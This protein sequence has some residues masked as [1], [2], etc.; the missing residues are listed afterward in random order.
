LH[1]FGATS[2]LDLTYGYD[3]RGNTESIVDAIETTYSRT[4]ITYDGVDR[5]ITASGIWGSGTYGYDHVGN[6]RSVTEG[7]SSTTVDY[8]NNRVDQVTQGGSVRQYQYDTYGNVSDNGSF[9]FT[10][11]DAQNLVLA[12]PY[13]SSG[14]LYSFDYDGENRRVVRYIGNQEKKFVYTSGGL[15]LGEY[16]NDITRAGEYFYLGANRIA[17]STVQNRVEASAGPDMEVDEGSLVTPDGTASSTPS[18]ASSTHFRRQ[19]SG[20]QVAIT[21]ASSSVATFTAPAGTYNSDLRFEL[22]VTDYLGNQDTDQVVVRIRPIDVDSDSVSDIWET[23]H[24]GSLSFSGSDDPDG[25]GLSNLV[26]YQNST[27]PNV[28]TYPNEPR[29]FRVAQGDGENRITWGA[30]ENALAFDIYWSLDSNVTS[31]SGNLISDVTSPYVH[32][33]VTNGQDYYYLLVARN[34]CCETLSTVAHAATGTNSWASA[35]TIPS[36]ISVESTDTDAYKSG[37]FKYLWKGDLFPQNEGGR[38]QQTALGLHSFNFYSGWEERSILSDFGTN[39]SEPEIA[40]GMNGSAVAIWME[41]PNT[42]VART[43]ERATGWSTESSWSFGTAVED[44]RVVIDDAGNSIIVFNYVDPVDMANNLYAIHYTP[45]GGWETPVSIEENGGGVLNF[46]ISKE[47]GIALLQFVGGGGNAGLNAKIYHP[48]TGWGAATWLQ[49]DGNQQVAFTRPSA[50]YH[51]VAVE[52]TGRMV[53]AWTS[54]IDTVVTRMYDPVVGWLAIESIDY[55]DP[56]QSIPT[57]SIRAT[58]DNS[59]IPIVAWSAFDEPLL[60]SFCSVGIEF[61]GA[62]FVTHRDTSAGWIPAKLIPMYVPEHEQCGVSGWQFGIAKG[63][64][65]GAYIVMRAYSGDGVFDTSAESALVAY[66]YSVESGIRYPTELIPWDQVSAGFWDR[67]IH[68]GESKPV[69]REEAGGSVM[70]FTS[71]SSHEF[72]AFPNAPLV[73]AGEN[74]IFT[75]GDTVPLDGSAEVPGSTATLQYRWRQIPRTAVTIPFNAFG[76]NP[77]G[78]SGAGQ[79]SYRQG[80]PVTLGD[81]SSAI[82]NFVAPSVT[83]RTRFWFELTATDANGISAVDTVAIDVLPP[84]IDPVANAGAD[85]TVDEG[86]TVTLDGSGSSDQD[87][88]LQQY[89]WTQLN[90]PTVTLQEIPGGPGMPSTSVSFVAPDVNQDTVLTFRLEVTDDR[91]GISSDEVA[92]TVRDPSVSSDTMPPVVTPPANITTEATAVLTPVTLGTATATDDVDGALTPTADQSGPFAV[93]THTITWCATD[94]A[95]NIGSATQ[96]VTIQDTTVPLLTVPADVTV[97]A[98]APATVN[99]GNATAA[100]I[101]SVTIT[102]DAPATYPNGSTTV[103]W[104]A[105]DANGNSATGT[106]SV[107]VNTPPPGNTINGTSG[108]DFLEGTA[109]SDT[110]N[111]EGGNDE[112]L[113]RE[114]DDTLNGGSGNDWLDGG[115]GADVMTGGTGNDTFVVDDTGDQVNE[116][117]GEGNDEVRSSVSYVL[118]AAVE[119][120]SLQGTADVDGT[121]NDLGNTMLGNGGANTL[122]GLDGGDSLSGDAGNDTRDGGAGN[123]WLDGGSGADIMTGGTGDDTFIV[124]DAGDQVNEQAGEGSDEVRSHVSYV[125][126]AAVENLNLQ[127]TAAIDGTGNDAANTLSALEGNDSLDSYSGN[128]TLEGGPGNDWLGGGADNDS[129]LFGAGH[130]EDTLMEASEAGSDDQIQYQGAIT[131]YDLWFH[132]YADDLVIYRLGSGDQITVRNWYTDPNQWI[133]R[134]TA[135]GSELT[136]SNVQSLVDAMTPYG[137]PVNGVV[138]LTT[139]QQAID[140]AIDAAWQ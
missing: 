71:Y 25:D 123:D 16:R 45:G 61:A 81:S 7:S 50:A 4:N 79:W 138:N 77:I 26:E 14:N 107:T 12:T 124:D 59:G 30:T 6:M 76:P 130:G 69:A 37:D 32:T 98:T 67:L 132:H 113:G 128:D 86:T 118:S 119:H 34:G 127:G 8:L 27:D 41:G 78:A 108:N 114:G 70:A 87:G 22:Q 112:L 89:T 125:L 97:T 117:A 36:D 139:Q 35:V 90:T 44:P 24:F 19:L 60:G 28:Q 115:S 126:P 40:V 9:S 66:P 101:F 131:R 82:T 120:L 91:G 92:I 88:I 56:A 129:Y 134:I 1:A 20:P 104:T 111:G 84:N 65:E 57:S 93:G 10:Y 3:E 39:L 38:L 13:S 5:M 49:D 136:A 58:F 11:D 80:I 15:L 85:E 102:N 54:S 140:A 75:V 53:V 135:S 33:G 2:Y 46:V 74:R 43:Y 48:S 29:Y 103:T 109:G 52:S 94:T 95:G 21:N 31:Q 18:S 72:I 100:N 116:Q 110:I 55:E 47:T 64:Y 17:S 42:L 23:N 137:P 51:S 99:I 62:T 133:E 63:M 122:T 73:K 96:S 68:G 83:E 106:Q 105:T 121:G